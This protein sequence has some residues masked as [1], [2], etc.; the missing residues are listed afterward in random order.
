M[1]KSRG[2][3]RGA[4]Q[5]PNNRNAAGLWACATVKA[6]REPGPSQVCDTL[7]ALGN[8]HHH[9][10]TALSGDRQVGAETWMGRVWVGSRA[11]PHVP[12]VAPHS[13]HPCSEPHRCTLE[14]PKARS[15]PGLIPP[16]HHPGSIL[17]RHL[18]PTLP[19]ATQLLHTAGAQPSS[20]PTPVHRGHEGSEDADAALSTPHYPVPEL[21][22]LG[23]GASWLPRVGTGILCALHF[24]WAQGISYQP[25]ENF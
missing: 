10:A 19:L 18:F 12:M 6:H 14:I 21:T 7:L 16:W 13:P 20:M 1:G 8:T 2:N 15:C 5:L 4:T 24:P 25:V 17:P 3:L 22:G 9:I 11:Q 23:E